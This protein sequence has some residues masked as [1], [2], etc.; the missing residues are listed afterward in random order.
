MLS[1]FSD[2]IKEKRFLKNLSEHKAI[3]SYNFARKNLW[4]PR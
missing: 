3:R 4:D 1:L 2:F